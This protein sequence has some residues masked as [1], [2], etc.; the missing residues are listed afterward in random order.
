MPA[1]GRW[2]GSFKICAIQTP[3][4]TP[5]VSAPAGMPETAGG[6]RWGGRAFGGG[7]VRAAYPR[8][9]DWSGDNRE[10]R[11]TRA[12][13]AR[14][15]MR[16]R[17]RGA[18]PPSLAAEEGKPDH[19]GTCAMSGTVGP[20]GSW[21]DYNHYEVSVTVANPRAVF[22]RDAIDMMGSIQSI[23]T[24][25]PGRSARR[26]WFN[27][28]ISLAPSKD[29]AAATAAVRLGPATCLNRGDA[30]RQSPR[31]S[32][33]DTRRPTNPKIGGTR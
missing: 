32:D 10:H 1:R 19:F 12:R 21:S 22:G 27:P 14:R 17:L 23:A 24:T 31:A 3:T 30:Q 11:P 9:T 25:A 16:R 20:P 5:S 6:G 28:G 26:K 33:L 15:R 2:H 7:L 8:Q 13:R 4:A 18:G 29:A